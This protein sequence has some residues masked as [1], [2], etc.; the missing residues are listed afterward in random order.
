MKI[1]IE[2]DDDLSDMERAREFVRKAD[3]DKHVEFVDTDDETD[4]FDIYSITVVL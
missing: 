1:I 4:Y 2:V 3:A